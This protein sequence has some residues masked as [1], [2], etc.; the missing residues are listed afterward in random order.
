MDNVADPLLLKEFDDENDDFVDFDVELEDGGV[1]RSV[2]GNAGDGDVIELI[3]DI[4]AGDS[5]EFSADDDHELEGVLDDT[6]SVDRRVS[7]SDELV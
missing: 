5:N 1:E 2:S 3:L 7:P 6:V 4:C